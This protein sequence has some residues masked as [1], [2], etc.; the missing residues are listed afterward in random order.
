MIFPK[1]NLSMRALEITFKVNKRS[2]MFLNIP[3]WSE[4]APGT[5]ERANERFEMF[6]NVH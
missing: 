4:N 5:L 3:E 6:W 2:G 1:K